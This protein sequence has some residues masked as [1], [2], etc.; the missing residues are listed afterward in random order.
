[1][2]KNYQ[3]PNE[4]NRF[5]FERPFEWNMKA[6]EILYRFCYRS[7]MKNFYAKFYSSNYDFE[8]VFQYCMLVL[9]NKVEKNGIPFG[10]NGNAYNFLYT[11][12]KFTSIKFVTQGKDKAL[13]LSALD[14]ADD[15]VY[16]MVEVS[17][18]Q[19][20]E[21]F[22]KFFD[23]RIKNNPK[24]LTPKQTKFYSTYK[25]AVLTYTNEKEIMAYVME[26]MKINKSYYGKLKTTMINIFRHYK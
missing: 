25:K 12:F 16:D 6:A 23:H 18:N 22:F 11:T 4:R 10:T 19:D 14:I 2:R 15:D 21:S 20:I 9:C 5:Y 3:N 17:G 7:F 1:M 26:I 24:A 13:D 8:D